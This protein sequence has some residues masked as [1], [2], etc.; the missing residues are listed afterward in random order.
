MKTTEHHV[1][2]S[3]EHGNDSCTSE[4]ISV[5]SAVKAKIRKPV[6]ELCHRTHTH[7]YPSKT[8]SHTQKFKDL[9]YRRENRRQRK[10]G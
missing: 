6:E 7:P 9:V 8:D 1:H 10:C 2:N 3:C 5:K 4:M